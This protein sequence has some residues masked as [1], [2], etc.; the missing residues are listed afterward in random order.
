MKNFQRNFFAFG[1]L[2]SLVKYCRAAPS[3]VGFK[4]LGNYRKPPNKKFGI[5]KKLNS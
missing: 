5:E 4:G 1:L 2:I 3:A